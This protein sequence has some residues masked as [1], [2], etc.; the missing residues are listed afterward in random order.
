M[1]KSRAAKAVSGLAPWIALLCMTCSCLSTIGCSGEESRSSDLVVPPSD[2]SRT[3]EA[4]VDEAPVEEAPVDEA[5]VDEAPVDEAPGQD[6][7]ASVGDSGGGTRDA[8]GDANGN[9]VGTGVRG[10]G[11]LKPTKFNPP[12][13]DNPMMIDVP[14]VGSDGV[15]SV[16]IPTDRDACVKMPGQVVETA[17][18]I[19]GGRNVRLIGGKLVP[20]ATETSGCRTEQGGPSNGKCPTTK[21]ATSL[22]IAGFMQSFTIEGLH[23]DNKNLTGADA[24]HSRAAA[25]GN[26]KRDVYIRNVITEG[27]T[28]Q[29]AG[30]HSDA[31]HTQNGGR[32]SVAI[33]GDNWT[34][35]SGQNTIVT[36]KD[37]AHGLYLRNTDIAED[38]RFKDGT[39]RCIPKEL[40]TRGGCNMN[41][42]INGGN[43]YPLSQTSF[44]N[45]FCGGGRIM[46]NGTKYTP[47]SLEG[48]HKGSPPGGAFVDPNKIGLNYNPGYDPCTK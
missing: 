45:V 41:T 20:R 2:D 43:P 21:L 48:T 1:M 46:I 12:K 35:R 25:S 23:I 17:L 33:Y 18:L 8:G 7:G 14:T 40:G 11:S 44:E 31:F 39:L 36:H 13:L 30:T 15:I 6:G 19:D 28:G 37:S 29:D 38:P 47:G 24:I 5:P 34:I 16:K 27:F 22:R 10:G 42:C 9:D 26:A 3:D 4:P 32:S